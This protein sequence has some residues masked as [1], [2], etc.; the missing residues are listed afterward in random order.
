MASTENNSIAR[1]QNFYTKWLLPL[2][3]K[4]ARTTGE[5][6]AQEKPVWLTPLII[7]SVLAIVMVLI[8][9]PIQRTQIQMGNNLPPDFQY[10]TPEQQAQFYQAQANQTSF[11]FL[12]VFPALSG[13]LKIWVPW[14]LLS[15]VLYLMLTLAG[16]RASSTRSYNLVAWSMVPF[17]IRFLV[18]IGIMLFS[19]SLITSPG[20]S[21]F[22]DSEATGLA[23][24]FRS[25][26]GYIDIYFIFQ[27]VLLVLGAIQLSGLTKVKTIL[28][29]LG[30]VLILLFLVAI[31]GLLSSALSGLSLTRGFYF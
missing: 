24:Y 10:Y 3:V 28:V 22:I 6:V 18:Q 8:A 9:A 31:P 30:S 26:L 19:K 11:L 4:P 7:L 14:F 23:A 2:F 5:I 13:L 15:I 16:S 27:V 29:T 1:K 12:Y 17:A 21:G 20:L 25:M